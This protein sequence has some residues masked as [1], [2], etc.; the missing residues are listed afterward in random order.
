[1]VALALMAMMFA[2]CAVTGSV[3]ATNNTT[4]ITDTTSIFG[5]SI[6][7]F[8]LLLV[9][10]IALIVFGFWMKHPYGFLASLILFVL[11]AAMYLCGY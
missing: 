1:M 4:G 3:E 11:A 6:F 5:I 8:I 9:G 2:F 7:T 10:F